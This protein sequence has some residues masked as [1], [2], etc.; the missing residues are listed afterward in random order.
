M[1]HVKVPCEAL[2]ELPSASSSDCD[3]TD[4]HIS[5]T[6]QNEPEQFLYAGKSA[7]EKWPL[8]FAISVCRL[9][10]AELLLSGFEM[11]SCFG[12]LSSLPS[13]GKTVCSALGSLRVRPPEAGVQPLDPSTRH[14]QVTDLDVMVLGF[15]GPGLLSARQMLCGH[16]PRLFS[17]VLV[18]I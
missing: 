5:F 9:V 3:D 16:A 18:C 15:S 8:S 4:A 13:L 17:I 11:S 14:R 6:E 12:L 10:M 2:L 7:E 1:A